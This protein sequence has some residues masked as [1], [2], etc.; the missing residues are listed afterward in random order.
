MPLT[1]AELRHALELIAKVELLHRNLLVDG[2]VVHSAIDHTPFEDLHDTD[3][4]GECPVCEALTLLK[5]LRTMLQE[6]AGLVTTPVH[7]DPP[8]SEPDPA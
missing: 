2:Q 1:Q 6:A 8:S 4:P 7:P 5:Q 3:T